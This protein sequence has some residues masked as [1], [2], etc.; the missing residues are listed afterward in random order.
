MSVL[1]VKGSNINDTIIM[2]VLHLTVYIISIGID[3]VSSSRQ[4]MTCHKLLLFNRNIVKSG[5]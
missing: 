3:K 4:S 1:L 2:K 5:V